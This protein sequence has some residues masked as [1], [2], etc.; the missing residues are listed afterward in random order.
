MHYSPPPPWS[1]APFILILLAIAV[2]PLLRKTAHWWEHNRNKL[3]VSLS[4]AALMLAYYAFVHPGV[5]VHGEGHGAG[6]ELASGFRAVEVVLEHAL[7][8]DYIPFI[9][10]LFSL[11]TISGGILLRGDIAARPLTNCAFLGTGAVLASFMGTTG[12]SMLLIRP[13]LRTN[14]ERRKVVHTVIFFTFIVSNIG[15][16]LTPLG[17]P[18]L[19]LGY[20]RGV[21]FW[22]TLNL[23]FP[24]LLANSVLIGIYYLWDSAAH[25]RER[26]ADLRADIVRVTPLSVCGA[27]NLFWLVCVVA[28][29]ATVD[30]SRKLPLLGVEPPQFAREALLLLL[31]AASWLTTPRNREIRRE[32]GF[33]FVAITEVAFLFVGIFIC[34]QAPVEYLRSEGGRLGLSRAPAFF[35][36]TGSLSSFLDNAPTYVVFFDAAKALSNTL[37]ASDPAVFIAVQDGVIRQ[38]FLLAVSLGAVFMGAN[39]YIGN[40]PNFMVKTIAEQSGVKMPSFFG[41]MVYSVGILIPLFVAI[42]LIFLV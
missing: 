32:N 4:L 10:L 11:Y 23:F 28:C 29:V 34:M 25:R 42:M 24:W 14:S 6:A 31:A 3:L 13:L 33:N 30:P 27:S 1:F 26:P 2:L 18:P 41:Y 7:L 15:G 39:T 17:D 21:P 35:W 9:V 36:A 37:Q 20:L 16:S 19:F 12:A 38:D 40:G 8:M 5:R 22:W